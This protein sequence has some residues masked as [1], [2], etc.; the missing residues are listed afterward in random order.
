MINS[1][2]SVA[3]MCMRLRVGSIF[4]LEIMALF[5]YLPTTQKGLL[6]PQGS[7]AASVP[8]W[9]I[10]EANVEIQQSILNN[11]KKHKKCGPYN[12]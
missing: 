9:A 12:Q 5:K 4:V 3:L 1:V 7:L 6:D 10:V 11:E 8:S 2:I